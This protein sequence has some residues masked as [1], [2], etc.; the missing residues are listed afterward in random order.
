MATHVLV[1]DSVSLFFC[2]KVK[3]DAG[4]KHSV[5][6]WRWKRTEVD[7]Y[8]QDYMHLTGDASSQYDAIS[9]FV[10]SSSVSVVH[11]SPFFEYYYNCT[12]VMEGVR[13]PLIPQFSIGGECWALMQRQ[14]S[15]HCL[16]FASF[17]QTLWCSGALEERKRSNGSL[18]APSLPLHFISCSCKEPKSPTK[19]KHIQETY[20]CGGFA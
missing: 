13:D 11:L 19:K 16:L 7:V 1:L 14:S 6:N 8:I 10:L 3:P 4:N 17:N 18:G 15:E 2:R 20:I 5:S 9:L 12:L